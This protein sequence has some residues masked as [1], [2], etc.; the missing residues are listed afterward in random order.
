MTSPRE[1]VPNGRNTG[2]EPGRTP[3]LKGELLE[4]EE[5]ERCKEHY[6]KERRAA[7][8]RE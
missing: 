8:I 2:T 6:A 3:A 5:K 4:M 1:S 7:R